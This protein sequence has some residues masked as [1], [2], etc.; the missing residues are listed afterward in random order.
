MSLNKKP[1]LSVYTS[2]E[3]KAELR[4]RFDTAIEFGDLGFPDNEQARR[5]ANPFLTSQMEIFDWP[6]DNRFELPEDYC[7]LDSTLESFEVSV[8]RSVDYYRTKGFMLQDIFAGPVN[9]GGIEATLRTM[10]GQDSAVVHVNAGLQSLMYQCGKVLVNGVLREGESKEPFYSNDI[11]ANYIWQIVVEASGGDPRNARR[12]DAN[13]QHAMVF[14]G[15]IADSVSLFVIAHEIAHITE[16]SASNISVD[17]L[18]L[19]ADS[20]AMEVLIADYRQYMESVGG[21]P[22]TNR[23]IYYLCFLLAPLLFL[24]IYFMV[25]CFKPLNRGKAEVNF[26]DYPSP[27]SRRN[28]LIDILRSEGIWS[29]IED[30]FVLFNAC[31]TSALRFMWDECKSTGRLRA[32]KLAVIES[33]NGTISKDYIPV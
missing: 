7:H 28:A 31:T 32:E 15:A 2:E 30:N 22:T 9:T 5:D 16:E 13:S 14:A 10:S 33:K 19:R 27:L 11:V 12:T 23:R 29:Q 4:E 1:D 20:L 8:A 3:M 21:K 25:C 18:E 6:K 26:G 24:E 17:E